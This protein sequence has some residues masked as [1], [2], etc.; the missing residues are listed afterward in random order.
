M[1]VA[2]TA[3]PFF[4]EGLQ[5]TLYIFI[6]AVIVGFIIGLIVALMRLSPLKI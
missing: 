2:K 5:I 6:I 3:F 1:E 4:L